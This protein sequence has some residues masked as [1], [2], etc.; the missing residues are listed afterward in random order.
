MMDV[1]T[2]RASNKSISVQY[3]SVNEFLGCPRKLK[4][5]LH[6]QTQTLEKIQKK[7]K[8][9]MT[10]VKQAHLTKPF[11]CDKLYF[12]LL[13]LLNEFTRLPSAHERN[14]NTTTNTDDGCENKKR[15]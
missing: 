1:K 2:K 9:Q 8:I 7:I 4:I 15:L 12:N 5:Q 10:D 14:T 3:T 6:I 11:L 13:D